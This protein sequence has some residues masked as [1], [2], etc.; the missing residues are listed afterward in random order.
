MELLE[1]ES[2]NLTDQEVRDYLE[3]ASEE[4]IGAM[5]RLPKFQQIDARVSNL[6]SIIADAEK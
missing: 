3:R 4:D 6:L 1:K 5:L 2:R